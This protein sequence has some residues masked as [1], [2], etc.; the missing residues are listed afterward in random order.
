MVDLASAVANGSDVNWDSVEQSTHDDQERKVVRELR[1]LS[2]MAGAVRTGAVKRLWKHLELKEEIGRGTFGVVYRAWDTHLE[3]DVALKLIG[4]SSVSQTFDWTRMLGEARRL[5]KVSHERVVTVHG[6]DIHGDEVGIWM[7]LVEGRTLEEQLA[8]QGPMGAREAAG[9]GIDLAS[10]LAAVHGAG[11]LHRDLKAQNVMRENGG[12]IVLMDFGSGLAQTSSAR[13]ADGMAGTPLYLAPELLEGA[14]PSA[15]S[16]I[17]SLGVLLYHLASNRYPV[18]GATRDEVEEAHRVGRRRSLRDVRPDLPPAFVAVVERALTRDPEARYST[19]GDFGAALAA[20][21]GL[22]PDAPAP[23]PKSLNPKSLNPKSLNVP[24]RR[25]WLLGAAGL[26]GAAVAGSAAWRVLGGP[27]GVGGVAGVANR[28]PATGSGPLGADVSLPTAALS[29]QV[30]ASL[31]ALRGGQNIRLSAGSRVQPGDK[32][33]LT[34]EASRDVFVYVVNQDDTGAMF[35]LFP[36][37]GHQ[38]ANPVAG[39][40]SHRLP[41]KN[42]EGEESYWVV[43]SAGGR[44][45]FSVFVT[46]ERPTMFEQILDRMPRAAETRAVVYTPVSADDLKT[47]RGVGGLATGPSPSGAPVIDA[48][49]GGLSPLPAGPESTSGLWER[50]IVL[51]NP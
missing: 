18:E 43:S 37:S 7:E 51:L 48:A 26:L 38:P 19:A 4:R 28:G 15:A 25:Q 9:V 14:K 13:M 5:A 27:G 20:M 2:D 50:E 8:I 22:P 23:N 10:A 16:D 44:E 32:L 29:Y 46:P 11:L 40:A 31:H 12:R 35:V 33:F 47:L 17:Y 39:R 24:S 34:V 1:V 49:F 42:A 6:A 30:A 21:A 36:L 45:R 41:G 3:R